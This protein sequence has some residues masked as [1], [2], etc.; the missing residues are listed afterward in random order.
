NGQC[1]GSYSVTRTWTATDA[2]GNTATASQTI[3]VEDTVAPVI[4]ELPATSTIE[5]PA[6]PQFAQA[7]ATDACGSAF[8]LTFNDV[9][10]QGQCAGS[11]SVTRT[12]TATDACGNA[13]TATQTINVQDVTPPTINTQAADLVVECDGSG[14]QDALNNWLSSHGGAAATDTC[15]NV[16]WTNN[17]NTIGN[18]CSAAVSVI[19]TATDA[20]GNAASTTATF[21]IVDTTAPVAPEAPAAVTVACAGEVPAAADLTATD[22]CAGD[23]AGVAV[24]TVTPGACANAYVITRTWTFTDTCNNQSSV[25][26][27]ITVND[28]VAPVAPQAPANVNVSCAGDVPAMVS[29]TATDNCGEQITAEGV[30]AIAAGNCPNS[31]VV[32]R[33]WTFTDVCGNSSSVS[34]TINVN[35]TEAPVAPAAPEN[36]TVTCAGD[37]PA[38]VTLTATDNCGDQISASGNDSIAQGNCPN[39]FVITRT[40]TFTDACGNASTAQQV[41]TVNDDVAPVAPQAP[42]DITLTCAGEVPAMISLTAMDNCGEMITVEGVDTTVQGGCP[43]MFITTRTWTFT[44]ACGNTSTAQQVITVSDNE[45]PVVQ[46]KV[47]VDMT[48]AC[49][50]EVPPMSQLTAEDNC[51]EV[52]T[53]DGVDATTPGDCPNSFVVTRTWTFTDACG[54]TTTAQ[55]I[56]T[57]DDNVAPTFNEQAPAD[58]TVSCDAVPTAATLTASDNCNGGATVTMSESTNT[59]ACAGSYTLVRTWTATDVC[60]NVATAVQNITVI[61]MTSPTFDQA[62]PANITVECDAIPTAAVLTATDNCGTATV[63]MTETTTPGACPSSYTLTRTWIATDVCGNPTTGQQVI[64]VIDSTAPFAN[65]T[66]DAVVNVTCDQIPAVPQLTFGDN[67]STVNQPVFAETIINQQAGSYTIVRT[68]TV[69][70]ACGN[71][72]TFTQTVNVTITN[73]DVNIPSR[74]CFTDI[75][76]VDLNALLPEGTPTGGT[77]ID[78]DGSGGLNGSNFVGNGVQLGTYTLEY[79][80]N[81]PNCPRTIKVIMTVDEDCGPFPC[82]DIVIHN[83]FSPNGDGLN[84]YF[85]IENIEQFECY[86][87]NKVEIYNRWGVLV[88]DTKQYDN[89]ANS[90]KGVSEGRVTVSKASELPTGTYFYIIEYTTSDGANVKKDGYLYLS[91]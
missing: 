37:V 54:N 30:D 1:A 81:D 82:N 58:I 40:W 64:T 23:V 57:V 59:G 44:D 51:G 63:A 86:P 18:D 13:S 38:M 17:F 89:A 75:T 14:S 4:A 39:S 9:T 26:Q 10:T 36:V 33:T 47:P 43:N 31:F 29:L 60:G 45:A 20:C 48:I 2:C 15:S 52:I 56:I 24:D 90:F 12:W 49:T 83:A 72:G 69:D 6:A 76:P 21:T 65:E 71:V 61:D 77:W 74:A 66:F 84:E 11:Y 32:T 87:T 67:C 35:D 62:I 91:R 85:S 88:Y 25:S 5:C 8:T 68:W 80:V 41:I 7:T 3:N 28:T 79:P 73:A 22:N 34:Q 78:V 70:D 42:A 50:A 27:T 16:V 19:F 55:Q 46:T 53:V